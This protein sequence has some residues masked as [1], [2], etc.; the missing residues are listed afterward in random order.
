MRRREEEERKRKEE[1]KRRREELEKRRIEE[2]E[3]RRNQWKK[4]E[5]QENYKK[6]QEVRNNHP[7]DTKFC[8]KCNKIVQKPNDNSVKDFGWKGGKNCP[9]CDKDNDKN[10]D[11]SVYSTCRVCG[12]GGCGRKIC[13]QCYEAAPSK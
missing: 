7:S 11:W 10:K 13:T 1:E 12:D 3:M 8:D 2:V 5:I 4:E 9:F 6:F